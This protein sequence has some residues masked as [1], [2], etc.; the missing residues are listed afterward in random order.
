M[1]DYQ[2]FTT[3]E[4]IL[5]E[6]VV[7]VDVR[8]RE[9]NFHYSVMDLS[10]NQKLKGDPLV[11]IDGVAVMNINKF[12]QE[13]PLKLYKLDVINHK[14]FL[15]SSVFNGI[16]GWTSYKK[17][18]ADYDLGDHATIIDYNGLQKEREFYSPV[19]ENKEAIS[20]HLPDF[21]NVLLWFPYIKIQSGNSKEL[22]FYTSDL[23]GK[24]AIQVQGIT[25]KGECVYS[26]TTF[27]VKK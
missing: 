22:S 15:G 2:R 26:T 18:M 11:L 21:R 20:N 19:Y 24:Y 1:D 5:R 6:Y 3:I 14:Y 7:L 27:E 16:L 12:M 4:E 23:P 17:D 25:K 10:N 9:G 8:K 13:D